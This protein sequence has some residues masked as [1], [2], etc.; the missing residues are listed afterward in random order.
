[1]PVTTGC[2]ATETDFLPPPDPEA[3]DALEELL[4]LLL[5][6]AGSASTAVA[7]TTTGAIRGMVLRRL[8]IIESP[9]D[10]VV[11]WCVRRGHAPRSARSARRRRTPASMPTAIKI[12][13]P[14]TKLA[15]L[16]LTLKKM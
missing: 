16:G 13:A 15:Q 1:M 12:T 7:A 9:S 6:H 14:V 10:L 3:A 2:M 11:G 8:W 4:E 5:P